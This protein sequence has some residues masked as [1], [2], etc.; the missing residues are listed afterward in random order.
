MSLRFTQLHIDAARNATDDFNLFHDKKRWAEIRNN[1]FQGP[2]VLGFQLAM[3]IE[4]RVRQHR[5]QQGE[6]AL[7]EEQGL[8]FSNYQFT[9]VNALRPDMPFELEIKKTHLKNERLLNNRVLIRHHEQGVMLMGNKSESDQ[10]LFLA[11]SELSGLPDLDDIDDR[12]FL[13]DQPFFLKRKF[14][15]TANGKNFLLGS[16]VEQS[17]YFDELEDQVRFPEMFPAALIS[18]ALLERAHKQQ[19]DFRRDP[20][21]YISHH[22]SVDR[23]LAAGLRS[24]DRLNILVQDPEIIEQARG[25]GVTGMTQHRYR[26]Y[27]LLSGNRILYRA[28]I[29]LIPLSEM[30]RLK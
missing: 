4:D 13:Q 6:A 11:E 30:I 14:M 2:I 9:F 29:S 28:E 7:I 24:N 23:G 16:L 8:G 22:I 21:V 19:H 15:N 20:M 1:P 12:S 18:C 25:I 10:P 17:D 26:C 3:L 5:R 27:G